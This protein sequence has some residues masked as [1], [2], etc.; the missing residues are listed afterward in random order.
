[1]GQSLPPLTWFRA[2][3][4]AA[5][6]LS[7]TRAAAELGLT[8][9]AIS[10][11]VRALEERLGAQLFQR[12]PRGLALTDAGR[13]L[14]PDVATAMASL[15]AA[16]AGFEPSTARDVL[17]IAASASIA[18]WVLV[19]RLAA[20]RARHPDISLRLV[21]TV[22]PDDF[23]ATNAD[24]EI[25]FGAADVVGHMAEPLAPNVIVA[26]TAPDLICDAATGFDWARLPEHPLIQPVGI[27]DRWSD[28]QKQF[29]IVP[30]AQPQ[31]LV[32]TH[33]LAV[34]LACAGAGIALTHILIAADALADGRLVSLPL[35][36]RI[37]KEGYYMA[38]HPSRVPGAQGLFA[39]WFRDVLRRSEGG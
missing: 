30:P 8:Q 31:F 37:A 5:R 33:G 10:Q 2:F 12:R 13:Q 27:S 9:S 38:L 6:H 36:K 23:S 4:S 3:D 35:A 22:W 32:D 26:V 25:R 15:T 11:H 34:D 18:Q 21:T 17:T 7:F 29:K 19:P 28:L 1:M 39:D 20:F 14:V 16:T 24:I